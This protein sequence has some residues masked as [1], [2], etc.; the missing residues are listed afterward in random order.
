MN[1]IEEPF[2]GDQEKKDLVKVESRL[3]EIEATNKDHLQGLTGHAD[4]KPR[5]ALFFVQKTG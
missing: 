2:L 4:N 3:I 1:Q 5:R